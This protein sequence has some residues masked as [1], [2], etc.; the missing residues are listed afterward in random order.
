MKS[1]SRPPLT[2]TPAAVVPSLNEFVK[3]QSEFTL[4]ASR[5]Q[6]SVGPG[7]TGCRTALIRICVHFGHDVSAD[8]IFPQF[9]V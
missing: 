6:E 4:M 9:F 2:I 3:V 7:G 8:V 5:C 1:T